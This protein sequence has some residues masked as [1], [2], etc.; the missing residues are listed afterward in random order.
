[1]CELILR[2]IVFLNHIVSC[3]GIYVDTEKM[4]EIK[5]LPIPLTHSDII[6]I[7]GLA[8]YYRTCLRCFVNFFSIDDFDSIKIY[9]RVVGNF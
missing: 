3:E 8:S 5:S 1:M 9:V 4:E 6:R 2:S 7:L